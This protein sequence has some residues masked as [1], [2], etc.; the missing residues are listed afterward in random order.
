MKKSKGNF[1]V[2]ITYK[3]YSMAA[4]YFETNS[5]RN[6]WFEKKAKLAF[7]GK[8]ISIEKIDR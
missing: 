8:I 3:D 2:V 4:F 7:D 1:G 5:K 6:S